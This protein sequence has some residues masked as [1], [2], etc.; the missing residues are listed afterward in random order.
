MDPVEPTPSDPMAIQKPAVEQD[1]KVRPAGTCCTDCV[2]NAPA[3]GLVS[4]VESAMTSTPTRMPRGHVPSARDR[5]RGATRQS[6]TVPPPE[7]FRRQQGYKRT[8][9][10]T[11]RRGRLYPARGSGWRVTAIDISDVAIIRAREAAE[12]A[13]AAFESVCGDVLATPFPARSFAISSRCSI[14]H[15]PRSPARPPCDRCSPRCAQKDC[16]SP[17]TNTSTA[18]TAST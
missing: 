10:R 2:R 11:Q 16:C 7:G 4:G 8:A 5:Q 13:A 3:V 12:L 17:A 1:T 9:K 18:S 14:R 6:I 15:C